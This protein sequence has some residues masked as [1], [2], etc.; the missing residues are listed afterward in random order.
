MEFRQRSNMTIRGTIQM[1]STTTRTEESDGTQGNIRYCGVDRQLNS[2]DF[3][4]EIW[5]ANAHGPLLLP[6]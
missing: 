3:F 6:K 4:C 1:G 5:L 2:E